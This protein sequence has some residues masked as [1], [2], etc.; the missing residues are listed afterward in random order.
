MSS[1]NLSSSV[2]LDLGSVFITELSLIRC[3]SY[4]SPS[5]NPSPSVSGSEGS[6]VTRIRTPLTIICQPASSSSSDK[7]SPSESTGLASCSKVGWGVTGGSCAIAIVEE[8]NDSTSTTA[9]I[10]DAVVIGPDLNKYASGLSISI[11]KKK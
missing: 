1:S 11:I 7:L 5:L 8:N 4:S 6:D 10:I 2:S 9:M 3:P